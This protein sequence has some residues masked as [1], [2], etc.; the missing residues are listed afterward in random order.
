MFNLSLP[1][2][3]VVLEGARQALAFSPHKP[4]L[5]KVRRLLHLKLLC[6]HFPR[7]QGRSS[8][9]SLWDAAE[10][11]GGGHIAMAPA[12]CC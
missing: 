9:V 4:W 11:H 3:Q 7:A 10:L 6:K 2:L 5:V 8:D 1:G 12:W